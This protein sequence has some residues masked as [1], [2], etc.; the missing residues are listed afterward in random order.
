[1]FIVREKQFRDTKMQ[2]LHRSLWHRAHRTKQSGL[3]CQKKKYCT[4]SDTRFFKLKHLKRRAMRSWDLQVAWQMWALNIFVAVSPAFPIFSCWK[5]MCQ[6]WCYDLWVVCWEGSMW[7]L[8]P[9]P[10]LLG[11]VCP[12]SG[13]RSLW[14]QTCWQYQASWHSQG[15]PVSAQGSTTIYVITPGCCSGKISR[16][17]VTFLWNE[18]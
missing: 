17:G 13:H 8:L 3:Y 7:N 11:R 10:D 16:K 18:N 15:A 4:H 6:G 9:P 12:S 5:G 14:V 2:N 1:M